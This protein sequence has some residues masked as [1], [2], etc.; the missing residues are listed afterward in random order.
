MLYVLQYSAVAST[1]AIFPNGNSECPISNSSV[2]FIIL[3]GVL[4]GV[5]ATLTA[6][7]VCF[8]CLKCRRLAQRCK[9]TQ[10]ATEMSTYVEIIGDDHNSVGKK[11]GIYYTFLHLINKCHGL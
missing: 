8:V 5:I 10:S 2:A 1:P 11:E 4:V 7:G 6:V 9:Y 3:A